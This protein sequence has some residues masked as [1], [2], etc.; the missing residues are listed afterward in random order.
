MAL[1][2]VHH[3]SGMDLLTAAGLTIDLVHPSSHGMQ[4][5]AVQLARRIESI[6]RP[7]DKVGYKLPRAE[8]K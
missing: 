5:I 7:R 6:I 4:T 3:I 8:M 2:N 1:A